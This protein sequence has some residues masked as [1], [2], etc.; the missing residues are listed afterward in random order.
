MNLPVPDSSD[1]KLVAGVAAGNRAAL[2]ELYDRHAAIL[3]GF[4]L[5]TLHDR[6]EA[7]DVLQET[8][9]QVWRKADDY[10]PARGEPLPWLTVIARSRALDRI[11]ARGSQERIDRE[12]GKSDSSPPGD[13]VVPGALESESRTRVREALARIPEE[14][15]EVLRQAYYLGLSQGEIAERSRKP[16]GT[17]KTQTRLGLRKLR[18]LLRGDDPAN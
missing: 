1:A 10:D 5:R 3:F 15:R 18:D 13:P 9:I 12:A 2:E 16:L 4:L 7:E 6:S 8:Y 11:R 17:V 14:Q